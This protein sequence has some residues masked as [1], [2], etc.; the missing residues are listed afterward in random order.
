MKLDW[1]HW[2][3]SLLKSVIGGAAASGS[4]W[5]GT[6]VAHAISVSVPIMDWRA[7]GAVLVTSSATNLFFYL[8]ESPLPKDLDNKD[9]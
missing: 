1:Q 2:T 7:L 3:Y 6:A 9:Q 8:K 4:A 5:L